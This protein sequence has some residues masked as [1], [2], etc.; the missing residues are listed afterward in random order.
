MQLPS[1]FYIKWKEYLINPINPTII[2][3]KNEQ[4]YLNFVNGDIIAVFRYKIKYAWMHMFGMKLIIVKH[5]IVL[6]QMKI[7]V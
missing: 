4:P 5:Y 7:M 2:T 3:L 6:N 1:H